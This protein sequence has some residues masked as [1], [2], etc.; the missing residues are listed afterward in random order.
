MADSSVPVRRL[1]V[2]LGSSVLTERPGRIDAAHLARLVEQFAA[3]RQASR[4]LV[5]VSSGAVACGMAALGLRTRPKDIAI[6]QACAAVGQVELMRLY[7]QSFA[8]HGVSVAQVLLTQSD[9][10]EAVRYR[11][12]MKTFETL[13]AK[14]IVP[15]VNENDTVAVEEI[16]FG[17]NDRLAALVACQLR[18]Q[19]LVVLSDVDGLLEDGRV[20]A[21]IDQ[22][23][24]T[25]HALALG[26]SRE[27]SVGGMASKLAAARIARHGGVPMIIANGKHS[28]I[29][30]DILEGKPI[31][32]LIAPPAARLEFRKWRIAFSMRKPLGSLVIDAGAVTAVVSGRKSL[33]P[34]GI[35]QVEGRFHAG[36]AITIMDEA[37][38][39]V[40]RG[41]SNFS[42]S[43]LARIRGLRTAQLAEALG[44]KPVKNEVVHRDHLVLTQDLAG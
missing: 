24:Q 12:A 10:A 35:R 19:L 14:G 31:G 40:A 17:D 2:K 32:T 36:D 4:E 20:I 16:A 28:T 43:E 18:A 23:D 26:A 29:L 30:S 15:I 42:S 38:Q 9:L 33:L 5:L 8:E 25:H 21:R 37:R 3:C 39:E 27:T 22:L 6:L 34:S 11:N 44:H 1:V 7:S 41:I 13:L